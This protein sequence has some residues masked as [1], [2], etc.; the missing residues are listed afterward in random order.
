M[1]RIPILNSS[2]LFFKNVRLFLSSPIKA[3]PKST[4]TPKFTKFQP[5]KDIDVH[6]RPVPPKKAREAPLADFELYAKLKSNNQLPEQQLTKMFEK[7][8]CN[9]ETI[10]SIMPDLPKIITPALVG[11]IETCSKY[12]TLTKNLKELWINLEAE[13]HNRLENITNEHTV[14]ILSSLSRVNKGSPQFYKHMEGFIIE[15]EI[16]FK[17][18]QFVEILASYSQMNYGSSLLLSTLSQEIVKSSKI[19]LR[20]GV[21][22]NKPGLSISQ[23]ARSAYQIKKCKNNIEGGYGLYKTLD[24]RIK[25]SL[26]ENRLNLREMIKLSQ[27]YLAANLGPNDLQEKLELEISKKEFNFTISEF[28]RLMDAIRHYYIKTNE[29]NEMC[30]KLTE[31]WLTEFKDSQLDWVLET[32]FTNER[33]MRTDSFTKKLV[34]CA[35]TRMKLVKSRNIAFI[36]YG[37]SNNKQYSKEIKEKIFAELEKSAQA[38]LSKFTINHLF[39][40]QKGFSIAKLGSFSFHTEIISEIR[41]RI[42]Q[43]SLKDYINFVKILQDFSDEWN[44]IL[45]SETLKIIINKFMSVV[46]LCEIDDCAKILEICYLT[47][48]NNIDLVEKLVGRLETNS[49]AL[50][51]KCFSL[52]YFLLAQYKAKNV[53][54][55]EETIKLLINKNGFNKLQH[56]DLILLANT[57]KIQNEELYKMLMNSKDFN[58]NL[59]KV[60]FA[61]INQKLGYLKILRS[62]NQIEKIKETIKNSKEPLIQESFKDYGKIKQ[63][64]IK[65]IAEKCDSKYKIIENYFDQE[66][67]HVFDMAIFEN[68]ELKLLILLNTASDFINENPRNLFKMIEFNQTELQKLKNNKIK[69]ID[70]IGK[71]EEIMEQINKNIPNLINNS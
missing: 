54:K 65:K 43:A 55:Y 3:D 23:L 70:L 7:G 46:N 34:D 30:M 22:S 41:K 47:N 66:N 39:K 12:P 33:L 53:E 49:Q 50:S 60:D 25:Y 4:L 27:W 63:G 5:K 17:P 28:A 67:M 31:K 20:D 40:M 9:I 15:S 44:A 2:R 19:T 32:Y 26:A 56:D 29:F 57:V 45:D 71:Q 58:E 14:T 52:A 68:D 6:R 18:K 21:I 59:A 42:A 38:K 51:E 64:I 48:I 36:S 11:I 16:P 61:K 35:I 13:V 62:L 69:I 37:L 24:D 8:I 1:L 10:N